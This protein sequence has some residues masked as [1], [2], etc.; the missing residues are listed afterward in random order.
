MISASGIDEKVWTGVTG[1]ESGPVMPMLLKISSFG[2]VAISL[3]RGVISITGASLGTM[4]RIVPSGIFISF[5]SLHLFCLFGCPAVGGFAKAM[6]MLAIASVCV[7][8]VGVSGPRR[9]KMERLRRLRLLDVEYIAVGELPASKRS[10]AMIPVS[11]YR[12]HS[13]WPQD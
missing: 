4:R 6:L 10:D 13:A 3:S 12:L 11:K 5:D 8:G 2:E 1:A 7:A 9:L